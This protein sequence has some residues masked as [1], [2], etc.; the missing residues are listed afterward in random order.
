M[1]NLLVWGLH[2]NIAQAVNMKTPRILNQAMKLAKRAD[3][4]INMSRRP[5]QRDAGSQD[6][7]KTGDAQASGS[8]GK[9]GYW[10]NIKQNKKCS[11]D[12]L[13]RLGVSPNAQGI[14]R[15]G[16]GQGI[17][18]S[19]EGVSIRRPKGILGLVRGQ[20]VQGTNARCGLLQRNRRNRRSNR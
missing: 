3:M 8:T 12:S 14:F 6:Q 18:S 10:K 1:K 7:K 11:L 20:L 9:K 5:G 4:A 2:S 13:E 17:P 15:R 19:M 16:T